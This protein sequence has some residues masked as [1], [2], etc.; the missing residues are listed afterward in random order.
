MLPI[1]VAILIALRPERGRKGTVVTL[2]SLSL[3]I[4]HVALFHP[5]LFWKRVRE[6]GL[7]LHFV[8]TP[9][10]VFAGSFAPFLAAWR[11]IWENVVVYGT[12]GALPNVVMMTARLPTGWNPLF[13]VGLLGGAAWAICEGRFLELPR[14]SLLLS[15]ATLTFMPG[16]GMQYMVWPMAVG[17][18]YPSFGLGLYAFIG[19]LFYWSSPLSLG[20]GIPIQP[21]PI[22]VWLVTAA[23]LALE[24]G[25]TR[26]AKEA[27]VRVA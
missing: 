26:S 11:A 23:W 18:L 2:L 13:A 8:V 4:K 15:L 25:K 16:F 3:L 1:L 9:Y 24:V 12:H 14:A 17:A 19:G 6:G 7:P 10:L 21:T 22:A 5:F 20:M 27:V